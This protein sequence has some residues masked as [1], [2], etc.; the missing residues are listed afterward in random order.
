MLHNKAN[1]FEVTEVI[2]TSERP[3]DC[4]PPTL[5][6]GVF[7]IYDLMYVWIDWYGYEA[8]TVY[9]YEWYSPDSI[10]IYSYENSRSSSSSGCSWGRISTQR[11]WENG[12]GEWTVRFYYDEILYHTG[13][14][15]FEDP[16]D[17]D[18]MVYQPESFSPGN[19]VIIA[20]HGNDR[21]VVSYYHNFTRMADD[22]S[23]L[24]IVPYFNE[25]EWN[26]YQRVFTEDFRADTFLKNIITSVATETGADATVLYFYGHSAGGQFSHRYILAH[27][28][29]IVRAVISAPGWWT[30]L[31]E[32]W[33]WAYGIGITDVIPDD[34]I[35]DLDE[36]NYVRKKVIVGELDTLR[37]SSLNQSER[38]DLQGLNRV[39][40]SAYWV[41]QMN[42]YSFERGLDSYLRYEIIPALG[43]SGSWSVKESIVEE[44]LF[45]DYP[46]PNVIGII[47]INNNEDSTNSLAVELIVTCQAEV[48]CGQVAIDTTT[49][50]SEYQDVEWSGEPGDIQTTTLSYVLSEDEGTKVVFCQI[51]DQEG[52]I[53]DPFA[54]AIVF[55]QLTDVADKRENRIRVPEKFRL[56]Q[57]YP[58]PFNPITTI[59]YALPEF[60]KIILAVYDLSGQAVEVLVNEE[61]PIGEYQIQW[62]AG[63]LA[64]GIYFY[65]LTVNNQTVTTRKMILLK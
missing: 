60:G 31:R 42:L 29:D 16:G 39:E 25:T 56:F 43:H 22:H 12:E 55:Y 19:G 47:E 62:D 26:G 4:T 48:G 59:Q 17:F 36:I 37:D 32:D 27:P 2:Y 3:Q 53:S 14:F 49:N 18:Y 1:A 7:T 44:F 63:G 38:A 13:T 24:L 33:L 10:L 64:S 57:N 30:F 8:G 9:R 58:N 34:V 28:E 11:L 40:R 46:I 20:V 5:H 23:V 52:N 15:I 50:F 45:G 51:M 6:E 21:T 65:R 35:F 41:N 61:Q 54:D